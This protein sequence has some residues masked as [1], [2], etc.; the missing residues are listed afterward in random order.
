[1]YGFPKKMSFVFENFDLFVMF[2]EVTNKR[3]QF[4]FFFTYSPELQNDSRFQLELC[5]AIKL[6]NY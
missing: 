2:S 5:H 4:G 6:S 1:M 3:R